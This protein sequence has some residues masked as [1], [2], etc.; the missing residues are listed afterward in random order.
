MG[1]SNAEAAR[2]GTVDDRLARRRGS[3]RRSGRARGLPGQGGGLDGRC[4]SRSAAR[5]LH[6]AGVG[7][8][9]EE[10]QALLPDAKSWPAFHHIAAHELSETEHRSSAICLLC[11]NDPAAR[12]RSGEL[13]R[14]MGLRRIDVGALSKPD[15]SRDHALLARS[16]ALQAA[17]TPASRITVRA[18][19][20]VRAGAGEEPEIYDLH[21]QQQ[22]TR[23]IH[24]IA[25]GPAAYHP[26]GRRPRPRRGTCRSRADR[27]TA[28]ARSTSMNFEA[29]GAARP[30]LS[31]TRFPTGR[32]RVTF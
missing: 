22:T 25:G 28:M 5:R 8:S 11:G 13:G 2:L 20:A 6:A 19:R 15:R 3:P 32:A 4:R 12:R 23:S 30:P 7:S 27:T 26:P 17:R 31:S 1:E 29:P 9:A 16:P 18:R 14:S 10:A 21:A 24:A